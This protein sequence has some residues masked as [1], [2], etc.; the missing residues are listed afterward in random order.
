MSDSAPVTVT[1]DTSLCVGSGTCTVT[2]PDHFRL[3]GDGV[4]EPLAPELP[5]DE[6]LRDAA[7]FCPVQAITIQ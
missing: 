5:D 4:A 3:N 6:D 7:D 1:V 2:A